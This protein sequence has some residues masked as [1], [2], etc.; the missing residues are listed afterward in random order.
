MSNGPDDQPLFLDEW[1]EQA[2]AS[3]LDVVEE[4]CMGLAHGQTP[5]R[6]WSDVVAETFAKHRRERLEARR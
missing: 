1:L 5:E 4:L 2:T 6:E 3:L